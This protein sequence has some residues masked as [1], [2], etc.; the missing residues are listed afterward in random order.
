MNASIDDQP[1]AYTAEYV[2]AMARFGEMVEVRVGHL[3]QNVPI[4]VRMIDKDSK[5][6]FENGLA[7]VLTTLFQMNLNGYTLVLPDM[8]GGNAYNSDK[9]TKEL[10]I[11]WTQA[12]TFMPSIQF[13][14]TPW[15]FDNEVRSFND[16]SKN[17]YNNLKK[18]TVQLVYLLLTS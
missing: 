4:F 16:F 18:I 7:T 15:D 2:R 6:G 1:E 8:V 14:I 9:L 3:T 5:W 17:V 11:R 10:M 13:S 12:N